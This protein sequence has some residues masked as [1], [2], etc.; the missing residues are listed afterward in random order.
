MAQVGRPSKYTS[1]MLPIV[2]ELMKE[3]ASLIEVSAAIGVNDETI[4]DWKDPKSP[5]YKEEFSVAIQEG[6][7]LSAAWWQR[8]GRTNLKEKDF[9]TGLWYANMKNRFG[10]RD[11][12]ETEQT[13][14]ADVTSNGEA[15]SDRSMLDDIMQALK[16]KTAEEAK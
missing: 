1:D 15:I 5:R 12:T 2:I 10:W 16:D 4:Q 13:I 3:G 9:Q 14:V 7:R 8:M 11:K 6:V